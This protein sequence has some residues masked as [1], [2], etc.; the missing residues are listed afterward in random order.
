MMKTAE[1]EHIKIQHAFVVTWCSGDHDKQ[2]YIQC[3]ATWATLLA[4]HLV[5]LRTLYDWTV[6]FT[7]FIIRKNGLL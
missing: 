2:R 6:R 4:S 1:L 5:M 3:V 7:C